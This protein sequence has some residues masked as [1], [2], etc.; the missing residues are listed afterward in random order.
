MNERE[1]MTADEIQIG[2]TIEVT[3]PG[4]P[5]W[6]IPVTVQTVTVTAANRPALLVDVAEAIEQGG[7]TIRVIG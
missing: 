2:Q 7:A 1:S 4:V 5:E 6:S 3:L